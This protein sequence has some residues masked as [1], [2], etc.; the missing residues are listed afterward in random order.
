MRKSLAEPLLENPSTLGLLKQ[1]EAFA[2]DLAGGVIS[3]RGDEILDELLEFGGDRHV[4]ACPV[5]HN[6]SLSGVALCVNY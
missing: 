2:K 1:A 3:A 4:Y 5:C 6:T